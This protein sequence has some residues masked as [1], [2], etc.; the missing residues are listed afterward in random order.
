MTTLTPE[1]IEAIRKR[2]ERLR[3]KDGDDLSP[4]AEDREALLVHIAEQAEALEA[5]ERRA[6]EAEA[7]AR[8]QLAEDKHTLAEGIRT[9]RV[10]LGNAEA[11]RDT[12]R[13]RV[14][15]LEKTVSLLRSASRGAAKIV[16]AAMK[17]D[18]TND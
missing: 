14:A 18:Q 2:A 13:A 4:S 10:L 8:E 5:A 12:L 3:E 16:D 15:E 17:K 7:K 6:G 9:M 1:Q 11:E